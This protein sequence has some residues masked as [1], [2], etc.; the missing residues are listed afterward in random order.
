MASR[1]SK[2]TES[3]V[4]IP[5]IVSLFS[6]RQY[7]ARHYV[8]ALWP[9]YQKDRSPRELVDAVDGGAQRRAC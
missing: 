7:A 8:R 5:I 6:E 3:P 4:D 9:I 1:L 2:K